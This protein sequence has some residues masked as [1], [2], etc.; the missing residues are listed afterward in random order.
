MNNILVRFPTAPDNVTVELFTSKCVKVYGCEGGGQ[1]DPCVDNFINHATEVSGGY[2]TYLLTHTRLLAE[3]L[4]APEQ[5][6]KKLVCDWLNQCILIDVITELL[7]LSPRDRQT[8]CVDT[9]NP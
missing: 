7:T 5:V 9:D 8:W 3:V 6:L 2:L 4:H 1:R